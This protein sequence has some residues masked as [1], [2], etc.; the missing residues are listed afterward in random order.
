M[1][2]PKRTSDLVGAIA[3]ARATEQSELMFRR[4]TF[5]IFEEPLHEPGLA[6][7]AVSL[8]EIAPELGS[9]SEGFRSPEDPAPAAASVTTDRAQTAAADSRRVFAGARA[10]AVG[11]L[12]TVAVAGGYVLA[13]PSDPPERSER[14]AGRKAI[15][16]P[17]RLP[18]MPSPLRARS[19]PTTRPKRKAPSSQRGSQPVRP[20]PPRV[21]RR[22]RRRAPAAIP[23]P[24]SSVPA[25][26]LP[27]PSAPEFL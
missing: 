26:R 19:R 18:Q 10:A 23:P 20:H 3:R 8:V 14:S 2:T 5:D 27:A 11:A 22:S 4:E 9:G 21:P 1:S 15:R 12:L 13:R 24:P 16:E 7:A 25:P 6:D 17:A